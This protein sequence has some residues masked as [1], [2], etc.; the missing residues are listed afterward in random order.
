MYY[1]LL[2]GV[3]VVIKFKF[4]I[5][6]INEKKIRV[7]N[8]PYTK[9][10]HI[11]KKM[12]VSKKIKNA[13][14]QE[15]PLKDNNIKD[16]IIEG[17]Y[18]YTPKQREHIVSFS[19]GKDSTAMLIRMLEL[20]MQVDRIV[21]ADTKYEFEE[22]YEYIDKVEKYIQNRFGTQYKIQKIT[23]DEDFEEWI[24]G[25]VTRGKNKGMMRGFPLVVYGCFW[26]RESKQL[27]LNKIMKGHHRYIGI[28][29]DERKRA[30]TS[31]DDALIKY[32]LIEWGWTEDMCMEYLEKIDLVNPLYSSS[33]SRTG[34]W[35]CPKQSMGA[36]EELYKKHP[37]K[38]EQLKEWESKLENPIHPNYTTKDLE[39][40]F[41]KK[42]SD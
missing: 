33:V 32:P 15:Y 16:V 28:A 18:V 11:L 8:V 26:S 5:E 35:F 29:L 30:S 39:D 6:G 12:K 17:E 23:T 22:M 25:E 38:W 2:G 40:K 10:K 7:L 3:I 37:D 27:P 21:F 19:G 31:K 34:C 9:A 41:S 24:F 14:L 20:G 4:I 13:T 36:W 1:K 42:R